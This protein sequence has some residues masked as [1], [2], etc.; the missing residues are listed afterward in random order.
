MSLSYLTTRP[1]C[2]REVPQVPLAGDMRAYEGRAYRVE[3]VAWFGTKTT[4]AA[5]VR[6][7]R[8]PL[9]EGAVLP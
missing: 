4:W 1:S 6:C 8:L 2:W 9:L 5:Q 3:A 7:A